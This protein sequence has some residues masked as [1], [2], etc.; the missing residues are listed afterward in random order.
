VTAKVTAS[1]KFLIVKKIG[2]EKLL[3]HAQ[4]E[5]IPAPDLNIKRDPFKPPFLRLARTKKNPRPPARFTPLFFRFLEKN[6]GF[7]KKVKTHLTIRLYCDLFSNEKSPLFFGTFGS[8]NS[9]EYFNS[10]YMSSKY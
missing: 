3:P 9:P 7:L 8:F 4:I 1:L 10:I 6:F 2:I 5:F